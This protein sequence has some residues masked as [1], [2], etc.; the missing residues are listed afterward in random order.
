MDLETDPSHAL[1][2]D[3]VHA[4]PL[5]HPVSVRAA[6]TSS[7][8]DSNNNNS[9]NN[10]NSNSNTTA[11]PDTANKQH[12][13]YTAPNTETTTKDKHITSLHQE[14]SL[15]KQTLT[16]LTQ[17]TSQTASFWQTKHR[18]LHQQF[19][20]TDTQLRVLTAEAATQTT[21]ITALQQDRNQL[22]REAVE[23]DAEMDRLRGQV[24]DMKTFVSMST[25]TEGQ[26]SDGVFGEGM[27]RL[28]MG[29]QGWVVRYFRRR[30]LVDFDCLDATT[31]AELKRLAPT[32]EHHHHAPGAKVHLLQSIVSR[33]L[34]EMVFD[35]YFPGLSDEQVQRFHQME[36]T[37]SQLVRSEES[38]NHW[39]ASTLALL[40]R[41][42]IQNLQ[43]ETNTH[44]EEVTLRTKRILDAITTDGPGST[45][46][47][48]DSSHPSTRDSSLRSLVTDAVDLAQLLVA[49]KAVL[50]V[51]M[52]EVSPHQPA[53]FDPD[54]MEDVSGENEDEEALASREIW[55][56]VFPGLIK[57]GDE[58]G[59]RME[60]RNVIAKARVLVR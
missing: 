28:G 51:S 49:Q 41:D 13:N 29:V 20:H 4:S 33:I 15:L 34:V 38:I 1:R 44:I 2:T 36:E 19:L 23:R 3:P 31:L 14:L 32:Y 17:T 7:N 10:S 42:A 43:D 50:R 22:R 8:S 55:C 56:V 25:R 54:T 53:L 26:V 46:S 18:T 5:N 45:S 9:N 37:L 30:G 27:G 6:N 16:H 58:K 59:G 57:H 60:L 48:S 11:S 52:P 12:N 35:T 47:A 40:R 39:R 21:Q 24:R